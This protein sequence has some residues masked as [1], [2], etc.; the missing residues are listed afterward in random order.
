MRHKLQLKQL[1]G[2]TLFYRCNWPNKKFC[3]SFVFVKVFV[4]LCFLSTLYF[5]CQM[6]AIIS[7]SRCDKSNLVIFSCREINLIKCEHCF[8]KAFFALYTILL[9]VCRCTRHR[10]KF[11]GGKNET[12]VSRWWY[13]SFTAF[14]AHFPACSKKTSVC[15]SI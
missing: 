14:P 7:P 9:A 11:I 2:G 5:K 1:L 15:S 6:Y 13:C 4:L 3:D 12:G 10:R 8:S